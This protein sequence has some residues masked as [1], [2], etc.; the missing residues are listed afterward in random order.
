MKEVAFQNL[1]EMYSNNK[2]IFDKDAGRTE[3]ILTGYSTLQDLFHKSS[4]STNPSLKK[5]LH[6]AWFVQYLL[7]IND[8]NNVICIRKD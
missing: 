2:K 5:D 4:L 8:R 1:V 7:H 3:N 6:F